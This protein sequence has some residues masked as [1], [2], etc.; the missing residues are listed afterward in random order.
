MEVLFNF[1]NL[2]VKGKSYEDLETNEIKI[3][4]C[5][6]HKMLQMPKYA[7]I[8]PTI[9]DHFE[10]LL[11]VYQGILINKIDKLSEIY[12]IPYRNNFLAFDKLFKERANNKNKLSFF[13]ILDPLT[14]QDAETSLKKQI[15]LD[16]VIDELINKIKNEEEFCKKFLSYASKVA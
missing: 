1:K 11:S 10:Y 3:L 12:D 6:Y 4:L 15:L 14:N 13:E 8:H 7:K 5:N 2:Q 16:K 9:K